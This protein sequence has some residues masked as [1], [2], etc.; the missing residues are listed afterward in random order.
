[1]GQ[2]ASQIS[3]LILPRKK[4]RI[5]MLGLFHSGKKTILE[6]MDLG[7]T[8]RTS[9]VLLFIFSTQKGPRKSIFSQRGVLGV[10]F[11]V[12]STDRD[13]FPDV[14]REFREWIGKD[15][16]QHLPLLVFAN[17]RDLPSAMPVA[18]MVKRLGLNEV[19]AKW[20]LQESVALTGEGVFEGIEWLAGAIKERRS[21]ATVS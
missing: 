21:R 14:C 5:L 19:T 7:P 12:D 20:H 8:S 15:E 16:L 9:T 17:K 6:R 3:G 10:V 4:T 1:M 18:E 11:V 2:I 13:W